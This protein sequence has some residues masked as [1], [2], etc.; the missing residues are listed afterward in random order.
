MTARVTARRHWLPAVLIVGGT[1]LIPWLIGLAAE[2]PSTTTARHW[3]AAWAG[4][5]AMEAIGLLAT[6]VL[7]ARRDERGRLAAIATAT[8]LTADAWLDVMTAAAG[9]GQLI[10]VGMAIL[11]ELPMAAVCIAAAVRL[12]RNWPA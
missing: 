6:G 5:D 10:A 4:L 7:L 9:S 8:L 1:L 11:A 3:G 12:P 2:L